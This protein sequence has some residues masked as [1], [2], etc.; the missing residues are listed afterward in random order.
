[1]KR[2]KLLSLALTASFL[3]LLLSAADAPKKGADAAK[4]AARKAAKSESTGQAVNE[5]KSTPPE[6]IHV[7][8]GFKVELVY[9]VPGDKQGSWVNLCLDGKGRMIAS[10]QYGG[11][12]RFPLPPLGEPRDR[13]AIGPVES[14]AFEIQEIDELPNAQ[15]VAGNIAFR[16]ANSQDSW[17]R[18]SNVRR[19]VGAGA[20]GQR[21]RRKQ[22]NA[23]THHGRVAAFT[24][25]P[26]RCQARTDY[27]LS[28]RG[29][30]SSIAHGQKF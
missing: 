30:Q 27:L 24:N 17:P 28:L 26:A 10:D 25:A 5:N 22:E 18:T 13:A 6:R 3:A 15:I 14:E 8:K 7:A 4:K 11:L 21:Q 1:M 16:H 23:A 9:S 29:D 2:F 20:G 19:R 12:Y